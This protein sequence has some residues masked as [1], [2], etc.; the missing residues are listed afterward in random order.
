MPN[1]TPFRVEVL[2]RIPR[3]GQDLE[4]VVRQ[5]HMDEDVL[6]DFREYIPSRGVY[7]HG[8]LVP[9]SVLDALVGALQEAEVG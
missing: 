8:I 2:A 5:I 7:G 9:Q 4:I 1:E 6:T 3:E